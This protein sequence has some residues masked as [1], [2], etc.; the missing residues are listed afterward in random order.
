[1]HLGFAVKVI[2]RAGLKSHDGRRRENQPHLSVSLAYLRDI[3]L[4]LHHQHIHYYRFS[5]QLAP[6]IT[7]E[8][9]LFQQQKQEAIHELAH[10]GQMAT[11]YGIRLTCH[12]PLSVV[13][14]SQDETVRLQGRRWLARMAQLLDDMQLS[15]ESVIVLHVGGLYGEQKTALAS[16]LRS[17]EALPESTQR[18]IV[19]EHDGRFDIEALLW[20]HQRSGSP[21]VYDHL[22]HL[23]YNPAGISASEAMKLSLASW[24]EGVTPKM[25]FSSP[26]TS[27][28]LWQREQ[29]TFVEP[30]RWTQHADY[31]DPFAFRHFLEQMPAGASPDVMLEA[32][33]TDLAL[34]RLRRDLAEFAPALF[35]RHCPEP[36]PAIKESESPYEAWLPA[37]AAAEER[38]LVAV[39]NNQADWQRMQEKRW[40]R[41]PLRN[42]P[43]QVAADYIAFYQTKALAPE[44]WGIYTYA[45]VRRYQVVRRRDLLPAETQHPRA[46]ALY[47]KIILGQPR[48]L[49]KPV[50]SRHLRR[51]TF[52]PTT[53]KKLL[54]AQEI[55][56]LW[57][58][59]GRQIRLWQLLQEEGFQVERF[60]NLKEDSANYLA[61]LA[62]L[63]KNKRIAIFCGEVPPETLPG[64]VWLPCPPEEMQTI[65]DDYL[66]IETWRSLLE[67][68]Q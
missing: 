42:A 15:A 38:V 39:L 54:A 13:L 46:N 55:N 58:G 8:E 36:V 44:S 30:P 37:D 53:L 40:Y 34:L 66:W 14:N 33:A 59:D 3:L 28:R 51:I 9:T 27:L 47:Y 17:Y 21:I 23:N 43:A 29:H 68:D 24:P 60:Y 16:F 26:R 56:D 4:Y 52:I 41:I 32:K 35:A 12:A 18:R 65:E 50:P 20:L 22:H 11:S 19:L 6:H 48:R 45:P 57:L 10:I 63:G 62:I 67:K 2:G 5:A 31:L 64:W 7:D 49:P 25:H 61:D 1:M